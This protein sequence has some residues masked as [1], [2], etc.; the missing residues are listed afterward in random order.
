MTPALSPRAI[1]IGSL[2]GLRQA[3]LLMSMIARPTARSSAMHA[4]GWTTASHRRRR[5][6]LFSFRRARRLDVVSE[7][8]KRMIPCQ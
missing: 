1:S 7:G 4:T 3:T 2:V 8:I 5:L 6:E